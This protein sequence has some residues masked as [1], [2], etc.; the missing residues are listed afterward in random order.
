[1]VRQRIRQPA[2]RPITPRNQIP[3]QTAMG[4]QTASERKTDINSS[5]IQTNVSNTPTSVLLISSALILA[6]PIA[7]III[8]SALP[9]DPV[10]VLTYGLIYLVAV[11]YMFI[12]GTIIPS[13]VSTSGKK[14]KH[15]NKNAISTAGLGLVLTGLL[16]PVIHVIFVLFGAPVT[17]F[18]LETFLTS[19]HVALLSI[20]PLICTMPLETGTWTLIL[21]MR[22]PISETYGGAI[23]TIIGAWLGAIPIPLDWDREWQKWPVTIIFGAYAGCVAGRLIG[24]LLSKK[25]IA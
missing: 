25:N 18:V 10:L 11:E 8:T 9:S 13:T 6:L 24:S 1:M 16:V 14:K 12:L 2:D 19:V 23:G 4:L 7:T 17:T 5:L 21:S 20:F 22:A 15:G 3:V